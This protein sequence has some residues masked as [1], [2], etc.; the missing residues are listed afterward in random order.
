ML[1][2]INLLIIYIIASVWVPSGQSL[3]FQLLRLLLLLSLLFMTY[4]LQQ[5]FPMTIMCPDLKNLTKN[6][7]MI[8]QVPAHLQHLP[9]ILHMASWA[10]TPSFQSCPTNLRGL[11][12][13]FMISGSQV[14]IFYP[15]QLIEA[16]LM[17]M[18]PSIL[19]RFG[20]SCI[21]ALACKLL[22]LLSLLSLLK[23]TALL[24]NVSTYEFL[25]CM[26]V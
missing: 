26:R 10:I 18:E 2:P 21:S 14:S 5:W 4:W 25:F 9:F 23:V 16:I 17:C 24:K 3:L 15:C 8:L 19:I 6:L 20:S 22:T 1:L 11:Y 7:G 12:M 13:S